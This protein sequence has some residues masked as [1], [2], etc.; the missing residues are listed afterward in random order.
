MVSELCAGELIM[1]KLSILKPRRKFHLPSFDFSHTF[2]AFQYRNY[3][4]WFIGQL[5]SLFGTWMQSTAEGFLI[6]ELT[7]SAAYLGLVGFANGIPAWLFMLYGGV[8]SDRMPRRNLLAITQ[9]IM[10]VLAFILA[11]L[12]FSGAIQPWHIILLAFLLG[13]ANAFDAPAR[14]AFISE[15]VERPVMGNAIALNS[16]MYNI[17][18]AVG[19]ALAGLTYA[20]LGPAWCFTINGISFIAVI[21]ALL[22]MRMPPFVAAGH[23]TSALGELRDGLNFVAKHSSVRALIL[24]V[25][26]ATLLGISH[27]TLLPEW[28]V[29][30]LHGGVTI[31]G[32]ML[33]ARGLGALSGA[34]MIASLGAFRFHGKLLNLGLIILPFSLMIFSVIRWA[35]LALLTLAVVGWGWIVTVNL[36][37]IL[38]QALVSDEL[39]G[40][41]MGIFSLTFQGTMP[42]GALLVGSTAEWLGSPITIFSAAALLFIFAWWVWLR[43]PQVRR[44][45]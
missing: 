21:A 18:I 23:H 4:L 9:S 2:A 31:N 35:P 15:L 29:D 12:T 22:S 43:M 1:Q 28:A 17:A 24:I 5:A 14:M 41:V 10:M 27:A 36:C 16:G 38:T 3:R 19:P 32:L 25:G 6:Y 37:N 7:H 39:R 45:E 34:L 33:S 26:A 11:G 20:W 8:I 44:L 40:R 13:I 42:I 30:V